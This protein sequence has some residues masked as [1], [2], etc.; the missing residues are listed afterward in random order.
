MAGAGGYRF[1][2]GSVLFYLFIGFILTVGDG[3]GYKYLAADID[4]PEP[5]IAQTSGNWLLDLITAG[6]TWAANQL[7]TF[8]TILINP[9]S[10]I[11]FLSWFSLAILITNVYIIITSVIP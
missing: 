5:A 1:I 2:F 4:I 3:E 10:G 7:T 11:G 6:F 8:F 9:F